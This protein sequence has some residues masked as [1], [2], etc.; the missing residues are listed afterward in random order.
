[1]HLARVT[2]LALYRG[3]RYPAPTLNIATAMPRLL[4]TIAYTLLLPV[5]LLRL[6]W[7]SR[8][9]PAYR[10]RW[11]ERFGVFPAPDFDHNNPV[12]WLHAVSVGETLA[13]VPLIKRLQLEHPDWQWI[14][15]TTTPTGS[16]RVRATFGNRVYHV[17]APYD[18]PV[19][20][21]AF[22]KRIRPALCII[23]ETEL[24]PNMLHSCCIRKIP[25]VIANARLSEKSAR[26]YKKLSPL[27]H[28][29][30]ADVCMI[31]AQQQADGNRF[32][33]LGLK[34][35]KLAVTGSIKFDLD[36]DNDILSKAAVLR[37]QWSFAETRKVFL[38][39]STHPGEDE[40]IL[41]TFSTLKK[42]FPDLLLVL[43]PRH[44]ERFS[45]VAAQCEQAGW[46]V[47]KRSMNTAINQ[48]TDIVIG[49]TMG[50][51][52]AFYG[53]ADIAFVGGSL[54]P[55]GGHNLIEPAA[56]ACPVISGP[57]LFNFS[58]VARLLQE[59]RALAIAQN[60]DELTATIGKWL[61]DEAQRKNSGDRAKEVAESNRGALQKLCS[62]IAEIKKAA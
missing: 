32:I 50:E 17:Y 62:L 60:T 42:Q 3:H 22:L 35:E 52:L 25:V 45:T 55:V 40:I 24:W 61:S 57:Y 46:R 21:A 10:R 14:I 43:V 37:S 20:L 28:G 41:H 23:M 38:A 30:M 51:L 36:L 2:S 39:A 19:F 54:V 33:D 26:G 7:R 34:Q 8:L 12:I 9:A 16:E 49:D 31:A 29:M 27:T 4:Y 53:A 59:N 5:I 56:W 1:M 47:V 15:T 48:E 13:A 11:P 6:L 58:E 44:P 18:L